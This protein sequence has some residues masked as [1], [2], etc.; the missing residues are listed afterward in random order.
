[1]DEN[2]KISCLIPP[3]TSDRRW[4]IKVLTVE[5]Q[6]T[7]MLHNWIN[8]LTR[9]GY[10]FEILGYGE[11]W[12]GLSW[13]NKKFIERLSEEKEEMIF[14]LSDSTNTIFIRSPLQLMLAF[15]NYK[16]DLVI[17]ANQHLDVSTKATDIAQKRNLKSRYCIPVDG[18]IIGFRSAIL[19][20]LC[21]NFHVN[22]N[23]F[24]INWLINSLDSKLDIYATLN[25]NFNENDFELIEIVDKEKIRHVETKAY[26]C[27]ITFQQHNKHYDQL[28][29]LILGEEA[30]KINR[31][32]LSKFYEKKWLE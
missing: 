21:S 18:F 26:P 13:K 14:V 19:D 23:F 27:S 22:E 3:I 7:P 6:E 9:N 16:T 24:L 17:S 4:K 20:Y 28:S 10:D 5:T 31:Q 30:K 32:F 25:L 12:E 8:S 29:K 1:M 15:K 11:E 2:T